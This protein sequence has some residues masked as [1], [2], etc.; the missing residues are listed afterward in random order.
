MLLGKVSS[1]TADPDIDD[2]GAAE[3][4]PAVAYGYQGIRH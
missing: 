3:A 4:D 1:V 2:T